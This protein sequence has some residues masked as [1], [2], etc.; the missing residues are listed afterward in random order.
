MIT[1]IELQIISKILTTDNDEELNTLCGFDESY[2]SVFKPHI[3][4]VLDHYYKYGNSPDIFTFQSEFPD[5]T[6]VDVSESIEYLTTELKKNK[7]HIIL[8][9]TFNKIKELDGVDVGDVWSYIS[10]QCD[11]AHQLDASNP[12]DIIQDAEKRSNQILEFAKQTRIPTGFKEI[13]DLMYGGLSTVEELMLIL[14]RTNTGKS[15][16]CVKMMESAQAH[17]F[18]VLYYSPEMQSSYIGARF[19]T[20]RGHFENNKIST[21]KYTIEYKKYISNL[22]KETTSAYVLEDKDMPSG[23]V[24]P[25]GLRILVKQLNI[26]LLIVDGLDYLSDDH[27]SDNDIVKSKNICLDLFRLS[28]EMGCAVVIAVQANRATREEKDERGEPFP[29][30]YNI[31]GSDHPGRICTQAFALRQIFDSHTLDIRMEKSRISQNLHKVLTYSWDPNTGTVSFIPG[32]DDGQP[33]APQVVSPQLNSLPSHVP[34]NIETALEED[35]DEVE[36]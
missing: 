9:D 12:A 6:L 30:L 29:S 21:G 16:V 14:A 31:S 32:S 26:K 27:K 35:F 7:Q 25:Q 33:F 1:S 24:S 5:T 3:K 8:L 28:K 22:S 20:W 18:P 13:D 36:F 4:F 17:G 34:G 15:W 2:Y 19:D 23:R 11:K 10:T